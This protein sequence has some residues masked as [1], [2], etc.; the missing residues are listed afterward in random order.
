VVVVVVVL[1]SGAGVAV[2]KG[3]VDGAG[4]VR[5]SGTGTSVLAAGVPPSGAALPT[6]TVASGAAGGVGAG[7]GSTGGGGAPWGAKVATNVL[8]GPDTK[9]VITW[10]RSWQSSN[11][12]I[13]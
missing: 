1:D 11:G 2:S 9:A 5:R 8:P 10:V 7:A 13:A 12:G 4:T 3:G 6:S